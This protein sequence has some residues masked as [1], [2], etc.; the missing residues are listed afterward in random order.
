MSNSAS[1]SV[2]EIAS[3]Y[4][5]ALSVG[6]SLD[7]EESCSAF[8][9]VLG[10]RQALDFA[11]VWIRA[12]RLAAAEGPWHAQ[13]GPLRWIASKPRLPFGSEAPAVPTHDLR[14]L[15]AS[16]DGFELRLSAAPD[17]VLER[18]GEPVDVATFPLGDHGLLRVACR[19]PGRLDA[20]ECR[21]LLR[22]VDRF[23][24]SVAACLSH[25]N[26]LA[27]N[28]ERRRVQDRMAATSELLATL[29]DSLPVGVLVTAEDGTIANVN[30]T[31]CRLF[32][33]PREEILAL[34]T[35]EAI[36]P[37]AAL[38]AQ[39][40]ELLA[41]VEALLAGRE[42]SVR[43]RLRC[44]DG[45]SFEV[46]YAPFGDS[47]QSGHLWQFQDI[48]ESQLARRRLEDSELRHRLLLANA[49]DAVVTID[50]QGLVLDWNPL[51]EATFGYTREEAQGRRMSELIVPEKYREAHERGMA[52]YRETGEGPVLSR[53]IEIEALRRD[54]REFPI[55][56]TIHPVETGSATTFTAF[57]RDITE[58]RVVEK[59]KDDLVA[60]VSHELRTPLTSMQ[61]FVEMLLRRELT[62]DK[63]KEYLEIVHSESVRLARLIRDFL[64]IRTLE[65]GEVETKRDL[66]SLETILSEMVDVF[67]GSTD[68]K[69]FEVHAEEGVPHVAGDADR[70]RQVVA[71]LLSNAVKFSEDEPE[72]VVSLGRRGEEVHFTVRDRGLGIAEE[73]LGQLF[74]K[75]SRSEDARK[76]AIGGSGLGL[77]LVQEIVDAHDGRIEVESTLGEG[78]CFTVFLPAASASD[79]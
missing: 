32:G 63:Q 56:L 54:G 51:A 70:L 43:R 53:R 69:S 66:V 58:R 35:S 59:M 1:L 12:D 78:S 68:S 40:E 9:S 41:W 27:E 7:L 23:S 71:N 13:T 45:R 76:R 39:P 36:R 49:L 64:D 65:A 30:A 67:D 17:T 19:R 6:R 62:R 20:K 34:D 77:A 4:E 73:E 25:A 38:F 10:S 57:A 5:L 61:G 48:T 75:F 44:L 2:A 15:A 14:A 74:D 37:F 52:K 18:V 24:L 46:D 21:K 50:D 31:F 55:E 26:A 79:A 33:R 3:L 47:A 16:P 29:L 8:L 11:S 28:E 72:V 42:A 60:T 22:L